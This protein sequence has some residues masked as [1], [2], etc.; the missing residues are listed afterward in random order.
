MMQRRLCS[1]ILLLEAIVV[2]LAAPVLI[3]VESVDPARALWT[4]LGLATACLVTAG[5][6]RRPWG[7]WLG[8]A[9]QVGAL[10][11]GFEVGAMFA[12]GAIFLLL[13]LTAVRLGG[14]IDRDRAAAE[15]AAGSVAGE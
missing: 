14:M 15:A 6:L 12:L 8:W 9:V 2:G 11:L 4:A 7:Y 13:W 5:L 3:S 10:A 1:A